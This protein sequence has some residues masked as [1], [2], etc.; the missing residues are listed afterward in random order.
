MLV[1]KKRLQRERQ[2]WHKELQKQRGRVEELE[3]KLLEL[4][5]HLLDIRNAG[6]L[7]RENKVGNLRAISTISGIL[8]E[9]NRLAEDS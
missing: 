1:S 3:M 5:R 6:K 4:R 8:D 2:E 7:W 9:G